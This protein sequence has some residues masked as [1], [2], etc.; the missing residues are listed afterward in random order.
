M[1]ASPIWADA[2]GPTLHSVRAALHVASILDHRGSRKLDARTTYW[3]H[4]A[5]GSFAPS[6]LRVGETL[7]IDSGLVVEVQGV[8]H[9]TP[10][11]VG[12]LDGTMDDAVVAICVFA[13]D[14]LHHGV[15]KN[16]AEG[17]EVTLSTLIPDAARRE[18]ALL[19]LSRRFDDSVRRVVGAIGE[20]I[21][22]KVVRDD[23]MNLGYPDLARRVRHVSLESDQLGYDISAP[24]ISGPSRLLEV[25]AT[26][27]VG[28]EETTIYISR[29]EA[30]AGER[31]DNWSLVV[32]C[33]TDIEGPVK[34]WV[35]AP[36]LF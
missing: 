12:L 5:G 18:E 6:D 31:F 26:T 34:Y 21:V 27:N 9:L 25:K 19:A 1:T 22:L 28:V 20:E 17:L 11:L 16:P 14:Y 24:R 13:L 29:N 32:C 7:L 30:E 15:L 2:A 4:A 3:N 8:F 36:P 35:G 33:V 10:A 23:L